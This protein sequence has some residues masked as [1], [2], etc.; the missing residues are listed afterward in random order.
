[1]AERGG[2]AAQREPNLPDE[3]HDRSLA[4]GARDRDDGRRLAREQARR[5]ATERRAGVGD[6]DEGRAGDGGFSLG[7]DGRGPALQRVADMREAVVFRSGKRKEGVSRL[8]L[9]AVGGNAGDLAR[10]EF[11]ILILQ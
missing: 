11:I 4:A 7:D 8:D 3:G 5:G 2:L 9:A 6:P 1:G 10:S